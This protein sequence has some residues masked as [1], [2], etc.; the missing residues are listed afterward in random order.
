MIGI[1]GGTGEIGLE[2]VNLLNN[3]G[4]EKIKIGVRNKSTTVNKKDNLYEF[5][6]IKNRKSCFNFVKECD[7]IVN[8][9]NIREPDIYNLMH[10]ADKYNVKFID[11]NHHNS[12]RRSKNDIAIYHGIGASPGLTEALPKVMANDFDQLTKLKLYYV[13]LG[14]FTLSAAKEYLRY[15]KSGEVYATTV[16]ENGN[17]IPYTNDDSLINFPI[18]SGRWIRLPY[19]DRRTVKVCEQLNLK[20]AEFYT[21]MKEGYTYD[22]LR[23]IRTNCTGDIDKIAEKLVKLSKIDNLNQEKYSGFILEAEGIKN[24]F[25]S[26]KNL[27][28][29]SPSAARL[30]ALVVVATVLLSLESKV[31][32]CIHDMSTV[33][34]TE[35][36]LDKMTEIDSL[37]FHKFYKNN[38]LDSINTLRGEI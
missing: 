37:F 24:G 22:F 8:C 17:I 23:N 3:Y 30:T 9:T 11:V 12:Q 15:L 2:C 31:E 34:F 26:N 1:V 27:I 20:N 16:L 29:K 33:P 32:F 38:S 21:C 19:M 18:G 25:K 5:I 35:L 4:S 10:A 7:C 14:K 13:T 36:L 6:D 28:I